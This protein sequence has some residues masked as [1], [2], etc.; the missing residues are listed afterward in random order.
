MD[1]RVGI[2]KKNEGMVIIDDD[3]KEKYLFHKKGLTIFEIEHVIEGKHFDE[4][5]MYALQA[6]PYIDTV[7]DKG[8]TKSYEAVPLKKVPIESIKALQEVDEDKVDKLDFI[9]CAEDVV[10]PVIDNTLRDGHHRVAKAKKLGIKEI[11]V[12]ESRFR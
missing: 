3:I 10:V 1:K 11:Y 2:N 6:H 7:I 8:E 12:Y 5:L 9:R 4:I